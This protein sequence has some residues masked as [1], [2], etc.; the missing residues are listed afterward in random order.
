M[1]EEAGAQRGK[2]TYPEFRS[3][4]GELLGPSTT[5]L[6]PTLPDCEIA[7]HSWA[8]CVPGGGCGVLGRERATKEIF[9]DQHV[10]TRGCCPHGPC[11][12][13]PSPNTCLQAGSCAPKS[14]QTSPCLRK[15]QPENCVRYSD[16]ATHAL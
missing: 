11:G 15:L 13:T 1:E 16:S 6:A 10:L 8:E 3:L 7:T 12:P 4:E 2:I 5:H 14:R 9:T